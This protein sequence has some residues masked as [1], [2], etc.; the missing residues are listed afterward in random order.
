MTW[1]KRIFDFVCASILLVVLSPFLAW[2]CF[3]IWREGDGPIFYVAER[4]KT[5]DTAFGLYKFRTMSVSDAEESGATGGDKVDRITPLGATLRKR[6]IDELP[7]LWNIVKGDISFVGPRPPLRE[8]VERFPEVYGEVLKS[9]PGATG[10]ASLVYHRREGQLMATCSTPEET[11]ALYC[12]VC[13]P[14]KA[15]LDLIYQRNY[16]PCL[17]YWILAK[18]LSHVSSR[19][20]KN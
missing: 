17:D 8:F 3:R 9:W 14:A 12:R 11:D 19:K 2:V 1:E 16:R 4:M 20:L 7:Q 18:T 10:L 5:P 15:K 13:I 6:R